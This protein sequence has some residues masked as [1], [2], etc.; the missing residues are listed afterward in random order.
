MSAVAQMGL[1]LSV[2]TDNMLLLNLFAVRILFST[3]MLIHSSGRVRI[4][5]RICRRL[6]WKERGQEDSTTPAALE[7]AA[8]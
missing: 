7:P 5:P 2:N 1:S 8:P 4:E 3:A 6:C